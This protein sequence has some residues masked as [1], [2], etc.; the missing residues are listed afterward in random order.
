MIN[1][2]HECSFD[3]TGPP[4][5]GIF[6]PMRFALI[7]AGGSGT[8]LWPMSTTAMPKQLIPFIRGKSLL[9]LA[10]E[11]LEGLVE[12][13]RRWICAGESHREAILEALPGLSPACYL[14]EPE[15]RDTLNALAYAT[16]VIARTD[17]NATIGVFT[18]DHL[19]QPVDRFRDIVAA[20]YEVAEREE[21]ALV[22]FGIPPTSPATGYGYLR[23]GKQLA[24]GARVVA[25]FKEKPD[26]ATAERWVAEG[27]DRFLWNG[28]MFV[29]KAQ[30][31]LDCVKRYEPSTFDGIMQIAAAWGSGAFAA[32]IH[33]VYPA[34]RKISVDFAVMEKASRDPSLTVAAV[35]MVLSWTDIGSWPA[36]AETCPQDGAGN[37]LAAEKGLL[38]DSARTLVAS[39]DPGH[40][41]AVLGC[42]DLVIVHTPM[43]TL[44][45]RKDRID[46][47]KKLNALACER[48]GPQYV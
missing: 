46:E 25:E 32:T 48:F 35:P 2:Q 45:C 21:K 14:G 30:T 6:A 4:P 29:W 13:G 17:P 28:G 37:A 3:C 16:A 18:A 27:P 41:V 24:G 22:T 23:L 15:G 11:R 8:R 9:A 5:W 26:R 47:L 33:K 10:Y 40:L 7:L 42:E 19:I 43:A 20:G 44:V 12:S 31:F 34:L 1:Y 36:F 38:M 39:S